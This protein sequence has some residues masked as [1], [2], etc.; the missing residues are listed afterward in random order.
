MKTPI[1]KIGAAVL[2]VSLSCSF[3]AC[4]CADKKNKNS[5]VDESGL[6]LSGKMP[7]KLPDGLSW[8]D[9]TEDTALFDYLTE[10]VGGYFMS[11]IIRDRTQNTRLSHNV[12]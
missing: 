11:D 12:V 7:D 3:F 10:K 4:G 1:K 9:F 5:L 6:V 2:A 8:Y